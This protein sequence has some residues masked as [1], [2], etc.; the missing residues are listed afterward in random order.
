MNS[1]TLGEFAISAQPCL[2]ALSVSLVCQRCLSALL[3]LCSSSEN[4]K[5][6]GTRIAQVWK[7]EWND[8]MCFP[9]DFIESKT[10]KEGKHRIVVLWWH[11]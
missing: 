4:R 3:L 5:Q 7:N 11:T 6:D 9:D 2:S 8:D 10:E 1:V